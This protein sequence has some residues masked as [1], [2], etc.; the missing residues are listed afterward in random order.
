MA[1]GF[2]S[3]T[4]PLTEDSQTEAHLGVLWSNR[5]GLPYI[6]WGSHL[7][8]LQRGHRSP[9]G[10]KACLFLANGAGSSVRSHA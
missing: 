5:E 7:G 6:Y 9:Q 4:F 10:I 3:L 8:A 1:W 2:S